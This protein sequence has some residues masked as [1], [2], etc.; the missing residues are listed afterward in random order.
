M[1]IYDYQLRQKLRD[2]GI[3]PDKADLVD[4]AAQQSATITNTPT[5][6]QP[7]SSAFGAGA[8]S[9]GTGVLPST[10][11]IIAGSLAAAPITGG[12]SI[13]V[14]LGAGILTSI[15]A[16]KLQQKGIE[17]LSPELAQ[18]LQ[19]DVQEHPTATTV[20][21][22]ASALPT[23][24]PSFQSLP[25]A[26]RALRNILTISPKAPHA[27][28][29]GNL[30]NVGIGATIPAASRLTLDPEFR[31]K[32]LAGDPE[33]IAD[34][35][36]EVG[37]GAL[38]NDPRKWATKV[39]LHPNVYRDNADIFDAARAAQEKGAKDIKEAPVE[40]PADTTIRPKS[41]LEAE[42][43]FQVGPEGKVSKKTTGYLKEEQKPT[44]E[45]GAISDI[46]QQT[47][48]AKNEAIKLK[49]LNEAEAK[50]QAEAKE[51]ADTYKEQDKSVAKFHNIDYEK[52]F[53]PLSNEAK[54]ALRYD[55][56]NQSEAQMKQAEI[57]A[58]AK[59]E[60]EG[61]Q[62]LAGKKFKPEK[63]EAQPPEKPLEEAV[64]P[65]NQLSK[66][67]QDRALA[68]ETIKNAPEKVNTGAAEPTIVGEKPITVEQKVTPETEGTI[69]ERGTKKYSEEE[70]SKLPKKEYLL[71]EQKRRYRVVIDRLKD[72]HERASTDYEVAHSFL[73]DGSPELN[74]MYLRMRKIERAIKQRTG[75]LSQLEGPTDLSRQAETEATPESKLAEISG[76]RQEPL[77]S[78]AEKQNL[79]LKPTNR[80]FKM[81]QRLGIIRNVDVQKGTVTKADGTIVKGEALP[82]EGLKAAI[83]KINPKEATIDTV[84][85]ELTHVFRDDMLQH[86]TD[87]DKKLITKGDRVVE[88]SEEYKA[89]KEARDAEKKSST[90]DEWYA[91]H[92]GEDAIRRVLRTD[93][94]GKFKSFLKDFW[95]NVK[96]RYGNAESKDFVRL[97]SNKLINEASF[98]ETFA[99]TS[100]LNVKTSI[101]ETKHSEE[102]IPD[103]SPEGQKASI[104]KDFEDFKTQ[105]KTIKEDI[106][107]NIEEKN[108]YE[109]GTKE[110]N[111]L[112]EQYKKLSDAWFKHKDQANLDYPNLYKN[113]TKNAEEESSK[114]PKYEDIKHSED[115]Y[116]KL[117][118]AP[119]KYAGKFE[120]NEVL[121]E[122]HTY[123]LTKPISGHTKGSTVTQATLANKGYRIPDNIEQHDYSEMVANNEK[124]KKLKEG[125]FSENEESK[126]PVGSFKTQSLNKK[127][128]VVDVEKPAINLETNFAKDRIA[129]TKWLNETKGVPWKEA[130]EKAAKVYPLEKPFTKEK[131][132]TEEPKFS[133]DE[134]SKLP[135]E[136]RVGIPGFESPHSEMPGHTVY[137]GPL[138]SFERGKLDVGGYANFLREVKGWDDAKI[139]EHVKA[140]QGYEDNS[141]G[142]FRKK[143]SKLSEPEGELPKA[144]EDKTGVP[145]IEQ[146][147]SFDSEGNIIPDSHR[148]EPLL[149]FRR[150]NKFDWIRY[151]KWA[152]LSKEK[153]GLGLTEAEATK[154]A[155]DIGNIVNPDED[156]PGYFDKKSQEEEGNLP[157][158]NPQVNTPEFKKWF[159]DSK[160][161]DE[162]NNPLVV[163]HGTGA[164]YKGEGGN[165]TSFNKGSSGLIYFT[166]DPNYAYNFAKQ[167]TGGKNVNIM[168]T[169]LKV[170]N[171]IDLSKFPE[172]IPY[173]SWASRQRNEFREIQQ[174]AGIKPGSG[175][176]NSD[177]L[178]QYLRHSNEFVDG[179]K[180]QGYDGIKFSE[181]LKT[182]Y[183][184]FEPNQ[185]K[186][187][188]GNK[189]T[190]D[191]TNPDIRAQEQEGSLPTQKFAEDENTQKLK[192]VAKQNHIEPSTL[193][194]V[195]DE[196]ELH[197]GFLR[198]EIDKIPEPKIREAFKDFTEKLSENRGKYVNT[199]LRNVRNLADLSSLIKNIIEHPL[200]YLKQ[201]TKELQNV[202]QWFDN[203]QDNKPNID[204]S[205]NEEKIKDSIVD[206]LK[207]I[208]ED[209]IAKGFKEG[210][211]NPENLPQIPDGKVISEL[212][213]NPNSDK[214]NV[215]K[216]QFLDYQ[217]KEL[218][219]SDTE[220]AKN[221]KL[222]LKGFS[223]E[224]INIAEQYAHID[225]A[226]ELNIPPE[227]RE[228]NLLERL[229]RFTE[230]V[231]RRFAY[232]DA[233]QKP[234]GVLDL[235]K[236]YKGN[237]SVGHVF[238]N[239][240]GINPK[241]EA[242]LSS[243]GGIVRAGMMGPL[244]GIKDFTTNI[245]LGM[246]HQ[247][248]PLQTIKSTLDAWSNMSQNIADSFKTGRNRT[249][250]NALEWSDSPNLIAGLR[251]TRD[252]LSDVQGRNYLEQ[253]A[254]ATAFGMGRFTTMD[255]H[256]QFQKGNLSKQ[257]KKWFDD[258]GQGIDWK[259]GNLSNEDIQK[260]SARF[261]DSVQG[262]YD[263]KGLPAI[264]MEGSLSPVL[265]LARWNIE[266]ANNFMKHVVTPLRNGNPYPALM[267]TVGGI[268]GGAAVTKIVEAITGRKEKTAKP[269]EIAA[270][271]E[272]GKSTTLPI[273]YKMIG[274]ASY[275][276]YGGLLGDV[277]K[278]LADSTYGKNKPQWYNNV[279][280]EAGENIADSTFSLIKSI[281]EN[282]M[283]P[284]LITD[285]ISKVAED[286]LQSYRIILANVSAEKKQDI[287]R[288]NKFRD[289]RVYNTLAG[290]PIR[291]LS[292]EWGQSRFGPEDI[293][294]FKQTG[295]INEVVNSLP[296]LINKA[297]ENSK[298]GDTIDP[299]KLRS[300][301]GKLKRNSYQ[302]MPSP[303]T[304]PFRFIKYIAFLEK[305][306][307]KEAAQA[308]LTDYIQ[309]NA[310]NEAKSEAVPTF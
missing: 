276:G 75:E 128:E 156:D 270:I 181:D 198:P 132:T 206:S 158:Q 55:Y 149:S 148:S 244:T 136:N 36:L 291:D 281:N 286:N 159:G 68:A 106:I 237:T 202:R 130:F 193:P 197:L 116:S 142:F 120:G 295:D 251:R 218:G 259:K 223:S 73:P 221:L 56:K 133:E 20:G 165:F 101:G 1:P 155:R 28:D 173:E 200:D 62:Y 210:G 219:K 64:I 269:S 279:L 151:T 220:A 143:E 302:T 59:A 45:V 213:E 74:E 57:D 224:R 268:I 227:W 31:K 104:E 50:A 255:F 4:D 38:L 284:E 84:P 105:G 267:A 239:I 249:N 51:L 123:N 24:K 168:P 17:A 296:K 248:N 49:E 10:A 129:Y 294:K 48:K 99:K 174:K 63:V 139:N 43:I 83:V 254:R 53:Q 146:R 69:K 271:S 131:Q 233:I 3:D 238:D 18:Q 285:Y 86:G 138:M 308:R 27:A 52:D 209:Q 41:P 71:D 21:S 154:K 292:S 95:A 207:Q 7:K 160:V 170:S 113:E 153:G 184:V 262:T 77:I 92:T 192:M 266:K 283:S 195:R 108:K 299:E 203:K 40:E 60:K 93:G 250:M 298:E 80:L 290:N 58:Q 16:S 169:Y 90:V 166:T 157:K 13:P 189:G 186:S 225:K 265:S 112:E 12:M 194:V 125:K 208:K 175:I 176:W 5:T 89:W 242:V 245:T 85:H 6:I 297:L 37:G 162:K 137:E 303:D 122:F 204:L 214:S 98:S 216:Q 121:P 22:I 134:A 226:D 32:I 33:A 34:M 65:E 39:G 191:L 278:G 44:T 141:P 309:Q 61:K 103:I 107:K 96:A 97:M 119:V 272:E 115:E 241:E 11:G 179:L 274:L 2:Q 293:K 35:A 229:N 201:D 46:E 183:A 26:G 235:I 180:N 102:G 177:S 228:K 288:A 232:N 79:S 126:L 109:P 240:T 263:Y 135:K 215:Y 199:T 277:A 188:I 178:F 110:H 253:M 305:S 307:G 256:S 147:H 217:T 118:T 167:N 310:I 289:L 54:N 182:A 264:A 67:L 72:A 172:N 144:I 230:R 88:K 273:L 301:L 70:Q 42:G 252:V 163:Y 15:F 236:E 212:Q 282:G 30:L 87:S 231:S 100:P 145:G 19:T 25:G 81:F 261:V 185:I 260:M 47:I 258:F 164:N 8:R 91:T 306:Q 287:E 111:L 29:L 275:A 205:P 187:S 94:E 196:K 82:R 246:Q 257:G 150:G 152:T 243:I 222:F 23:L 280:I 124:L 76:K 161:V 247:Q 234:E 117:P 14:G 127:G 211:F 304:L 66:E 9:F 300:E 190:F 140:L 78:G 114:L 171:P